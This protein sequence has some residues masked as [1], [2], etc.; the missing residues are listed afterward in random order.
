MTDNKSSNDDEQIYQLDRRSLLKAAGVSAGSAA[1]VGG[2]SL[3][4][5][6][7]VPV[8]RAQAIAPL[9]AI[10]VGIAGLGVARAAIDRADQYNEARDIYNQTYAAI[11]SI[12]NAVTN[13]AARMGVDFA[14]GDP[15]NNYIVDEKTNELVNN[16]VESYY[17]EAARAYDEGLSEV[18]AQ[19]RARTAARK[20]LAS[21]EWQIATLWNGFCESLID[22]FDTSYSADQFSYWDWP[23]DVYYTN[24]PGYGD[25]AAS[26]PLAWS[27]GGSRYKEHI[28]TPSGY[29]GSESDGFF[30]I[31][32]FVDETPLETGELP[33]SD[34]PGDR[35]QIEIL[36]MLW[37]VDGSV[38]VPLSPYLGVDFA[39]ASAPSDQFE[40]TSLDISSYDLGDNPTLAA[41]PG[42]VYKIKHP[43]T[44][45]EYTIPFFKFRSLIEAARAHYQRIDNNIDSNV[46]D[47]YDSLDS[48]E[49]ELSDYVSLRDIAKDA[50]ISDETTAAQLAA[51]SSGQS[52]PEDMVTATIKID[53]GS[54]QTGTLYLDIAAD[55][56][57][58][59]EGET[60][61]SSEHNGGYFIDDSGGTTSL[62]GSESIQIVSIDGSE[63]LDYESRKYYGADGV[64]R[65]EIKSVLERNQKLYEQTQSGLG[66]G[67]LGLGGLG[68]GSSSLLLLG[69]VGVA[70]YLLGK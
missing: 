22:A 57:S 15:A 25:F 55:T 28:A 68:G 16:T 32:P 33:E 38:V 17:S 9:V 10:G 43:D 39:G 49:T 61:D 29:E 2:P 19:S 40:W 66:G 13:Q 14:A 69:G 44:A 8:G 59:S 42:S 21:A 65:S 12:D 51:V 6:D 4:D 11:S 31:R 36:E 20:V 34:F 26:Y 37:Y 70:A 1:A 7:Y 46:S 18:D 53:G 47:I 24:V 48:G 50:D 23:T 58:L 60:V 62:S 45:D 35:D 27:T 54:E 30:G 56:L 3:I 52:P 5:D 63:S 64:D 41:D 67:L